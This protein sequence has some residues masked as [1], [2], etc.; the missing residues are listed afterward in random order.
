MQTDSSEK[1]WGSKALNWEFRCSIL[2]GNVA[3]ILCEIFMCYFM[4]NVLC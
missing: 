1:V 2:K 3:N 4:C